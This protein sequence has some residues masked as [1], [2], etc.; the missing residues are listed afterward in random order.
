MKWKT[1]NDANNNRKVEYIRNGLLTLHIM[2]IID[3]PHKIE[4][5]AET[6]QILAGS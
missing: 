3:I 2:L 1:G 5:E 6:F 4:A